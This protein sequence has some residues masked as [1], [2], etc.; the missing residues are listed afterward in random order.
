MTYK[1]EDGDWELSLAATNLFDKFY[2]ASQYDQASESQGA[3]AEGLVG[4]PREV[5]VTIKRKF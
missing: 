4:R 1:P 5:F 2:Y 3:T